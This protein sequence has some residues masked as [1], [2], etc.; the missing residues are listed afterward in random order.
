MLKQKIQDSIDLGELPE[1]VAG[2]G[3][4]PQLLTVFGY[5][6]S[7]GQY[8]QI[9]EQALIEEGINFDHYTS[10]HKPKR[11]EIKKVCEVCGKEF[12]KEFSTKASKQRTCSYSCS[13]TLFRSGKDNPNYKEDS[14]NYRKRAFDTY[15]HE[16]SLCG[17]DKHPAALV[18]HHIDK[19]RN[20]NE[21]DNLIILCA[22][23]HAMAH[24]G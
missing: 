9:L 6:G 14:S 12:I 7:K 5:T 20:N 1:L 3:S 18:V 22:N 15:L 16:C 19:D 2:T 4:F 10:T 21:I 11:P 17:Y 13:N 24:W 23:C 8:K